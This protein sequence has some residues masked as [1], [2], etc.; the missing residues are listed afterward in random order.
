MPF[1]YDI[2]DAALTDGG[3]P[4][5]AGFTIP[6][7]AGLEGCYIFDGQPG[8][9]GRNYASG[10][11]A[12]SVIGAPVVD[13]KSARFSGSAYLDTGISET[14]SMSIIVVA[15][16]ST[17]PGTGNLASLF[18]NYNSNSAGGIGMWMQEPTLVRTNAIKDGASD[19]LNV[20][21]TTSNYA[22]LAYRV[23]SGGYSRLINFTNGDDVQSSGTGVRTLDVTRTL[24]VGRFY[25]TSYQAANDQMLCLIYSRLLSDLE[26]QSVVA[27]VREHCTRKGVVV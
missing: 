15:K 14:G 19:L 24:R 20:S 26:V 5:I 22:L 4:T 11:P 8:D 3:F 17:P 16:A 10:R 9:L 23:R 2:G 1:A 13:G 21:C 27:W 6:V 18:G 12:A 7:I 25:N